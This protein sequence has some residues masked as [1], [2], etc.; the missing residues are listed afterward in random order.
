M[1]ENNS[2]FKCYNK[3]LK[4]NKYSSNI[5]CSIQVAY[6]QFSGVKEGLKSN[7]R[8]TPTG[9]FLE[10]SSSTINTTDNFETKN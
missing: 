6:L 3:L 2:Y 8:K 10:I 1:L 5:Y 7:L 9:I 4:N